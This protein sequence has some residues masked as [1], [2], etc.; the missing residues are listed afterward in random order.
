[1][2]IKYL[3]NHLHTLYDNAVFVRDNID[4]VYENRH[5]LTITDEDHMIINM[6][7]DDD[8]IVK[9]YVDNMSEILSVHDCGTSQYIFPYTIHKIH[10]T[11]LKAIIKSLN[12][13][14]YLHL[15]Q[16]ILHDLHWIDVDYQACLPD[17]MSEDERS[18]Y[19]PTKIQ[20]N[21]MRQSLKDQLIIYPTT[22][23]ICA[24]K[25]TRGAFP[26]PSYL[27][28][29]YMPYT[30]SDVY[31]FLTKKLMKKGETIEFVRVRDGDSYIYAAQ[32]IDYRLKHINTFRG[33]LFTGLLAGD[34]FDTTGII[35]PDGRAYNAPDIMKAVP[36]N[37]HRYLSTLTCL[38]SM[39]GR[40]IGTIDFLH[41]YYGPGSFSTFDAI[42][43]EY[44]DVSVVTTSS[45]M[46]EDEYT[47]YT[48]LVRYGP[49]TMFTARL[50]EFICH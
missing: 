32:D 35:I 40:Y 1:M 15:F 14:K 11:L 31:M 48:P 16:N 41:Q 46:A 2:L 27:G 7:S 28:G 9:R 49:M 24:T 47:P 39:W 50:M 43:E 38:L 37:D 8:E 4:L 42:P 12:D 33:E 26:I 23:I 13:R 44:A 17:D 18:L 19:T 34:R 45:E 6:G 22:T 5:D 3:V 25:E 29:V 30:L 21:Y 10:P 20:E 36:Y